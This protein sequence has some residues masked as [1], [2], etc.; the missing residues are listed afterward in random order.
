MVFLSLWNRG[1]GEVRKF[2][3]CFEFLYLSVNICVLTSNEYAKEK[4]AICPS[5]A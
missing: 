2:G 5:Y 4:R 3:M 1:W